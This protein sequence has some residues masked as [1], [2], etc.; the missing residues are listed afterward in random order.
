MLLSVIQERRPL[1]CFSARYDEGEEMNAA[2]A[3]RPAMTKRLVCLANSRKPP[4]GRC[5]PVLFVLQLL[6]KL[7]A[8]GYLHVLE[9]AGGGFRIDVSPT[10]S[11]LL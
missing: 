2:E 8:S 3:P 10:L 1:L 5:K 9:F 4:Q 6:R 11:R 7:E